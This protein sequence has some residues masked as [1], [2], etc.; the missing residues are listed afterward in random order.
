MLVFEYLRLR[1]KPDADAGLRR[2]ARLIAGQFFNAEYASD[3]ISLRP[4][5]KK[6]R[7]SVPVHPTHKKCTA[8][9]P[10]PIVYTTMADDDRVQL[11]F[12]LAKWIVVDG[13]GRWR[14]DSSSSTPAL[15]CSKRWTSW[16]SRC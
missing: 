8:S 11:V 7:Q 12:A 15:A 14:R 10:T 3:V 9:Y 6:T 4:A 2:V 1:A 16:S 13:G 5:C